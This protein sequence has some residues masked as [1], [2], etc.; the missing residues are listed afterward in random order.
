[1]TLP[2]PLAVTLAVIE[3]LDALQVP[4]F[5]GGSF[6]SS[7]QGAARATL[8]ADIVADLQPEHVPAFIEELQNAFYL[9]PDTI[10][11]AVRRRG[12][13][14]LIHLKT[15]FKVDVFVNQGRPFEQSQ[16]AR[17]Q[18][19]QLSADPER[20]AYF[21]SPEDTVLAKLEW[22]RLGGEAS[23]RQWRDV[24][25][26]LRVQ[27]GRLDLGYLAT[28]AEQLGVTDLLRRA[29]DKLA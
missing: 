28:W 6:A 1:M 12:S 20:T 16:F 2:E 29:F 17:R 27:Q 9:D 23:D 4:Y 8:D 15:M 25:S 5:L 26:V 19:S 24:L 18:V 14:N 10:R 7:A 22:Y 13:F 11:H 3:V 21:S